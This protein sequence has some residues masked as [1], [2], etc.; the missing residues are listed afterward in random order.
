MSNSQ[1]KSPPSG[2]ID[3]NPLITISSSVFISLGDDNMAVGKAPT[4]NEN[5]P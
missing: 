4:Y 1:M 2:S 5:I 3:G